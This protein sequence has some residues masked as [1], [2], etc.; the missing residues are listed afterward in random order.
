MEIVI[1]KIVSLSGD[2]LA[3]LLCWLGY[4]IQDDLIRDR[5]LQLRSQVAKMCSRA[6][7]R[8]YSVRRV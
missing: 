4:V 1:S 2:V 6:I 5:Y 3:E 8:T 7:W